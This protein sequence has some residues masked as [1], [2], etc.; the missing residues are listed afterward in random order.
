MHSDILVPWK[1]RIKQDV[2]LLEDV[3]FVQTGSRF[4]DKI[5]EAV[6]HQLERLV[7]DVVVL[8]RQEEAK[9]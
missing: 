1:E 2:S 9:K 5:R 4:E 7:L 3:V 8:T 6:R